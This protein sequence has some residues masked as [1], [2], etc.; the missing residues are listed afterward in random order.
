M[1]AYN[2]VYRPR[3][4]S[5]CGGVFPFDS[6]FRYL[7]WALDTN[8]EER[9]K[10]KTVECGRAFFE[11]DKKHFTILD[12]PGHKSFVP[13]MI[14]GATQADLAVLVSQYGPFVSFCE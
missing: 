10:G 6:C 4:N 8:D 14:S 13:N 7:S 9:E 2:M 1:E 12:A 3:T 11:T 5:I